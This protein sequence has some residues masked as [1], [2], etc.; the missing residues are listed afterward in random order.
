MPHLPGERGAV[1]KAT[2]EGITFAGSQGQVTLKWR[3]LPV[4]SLIAIIPLLELGPPELVDAAAT[5]Y[6]VNHRDRGRR[7][8]REG[9]PVRDAAI[10][11]SVDQSLADARGMSVPKEGFRLV[12]DRWLSPQ[13]FARHEVAREITQSTKELAA[14]DAAARRAA[15]DR[16]LKLGDAARSPLHRA[17]LLRRAEIREDLAKAPVY[18]KLAELGAKRQEL[19]EAR[20]FA[21]AL[22]EDEV[23]YPYPYRP[24]EASAETFKQYQESQRE[25][26]IRVA[27]LR[28]AL[29]ATH[30]ASRSRRPSGRR[31]RSSP[32]S[33]GS[34]RRSPRPPSSRIRAGWCSCR[35][36]TR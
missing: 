27:K 34:S 3:V 22:I 28:D 36:P 13:E 32:R 4:H 5:L 12:D 19:D 25:V 17:L 15:F 30:L 16:M 31:S 1:L 14:P 10:K 8:P 6:R 21:L 35:R 7:P 23:K 24:P 11:A 9:E 29:G 2:E 20:A 26:N 18:A 33:P